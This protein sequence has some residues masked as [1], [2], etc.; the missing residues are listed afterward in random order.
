MVVNIKIY[1]IEEARVITRYNLQE[2]VLFP[3]RK[4]GNSQEKEKSVQLPH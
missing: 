2:S 1:Y 4:Y 3:Y